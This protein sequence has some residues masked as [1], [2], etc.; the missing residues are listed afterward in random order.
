[1]ANG[2]HC[3]QCRQF[4]LLEDFYVHSNG[5]PR[6]QCKRCVLDRRAKPNPETAR[7][8]QTNYRKRNHDKCLERSR[9][10]RKQ[11]LDYDKYRSANYRARKLNQTPPWSDLD[12]IKDIYINCPKGFHVDHIVPLKGKNVSGLHVPENLQYLPAK[13]NLAKRNIYK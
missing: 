2:L 11:N 10:W 13:E 9:V 8:S 7:I 6:L 3:N 4:L 1:M 5:K 12:K